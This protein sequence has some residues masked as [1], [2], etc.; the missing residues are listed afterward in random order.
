MKRKEEA[1]KAFTAAFPL[2][3]PVLTGFS[4]L[5]IAYGILMEKKGYGPLW[6]L[7]MSSIAFC[8]SMQYVAITLLTAVFDPIQAFLLSLMVN[9]RHLFYGICML[10]KYK[11]IG[12]V[13]NFL[14]Y[15]LCDETFSIVSSAKVPENVDRKWFYFWVS[16]L[17]YS[18]WVIASVIGGFLGSVIRMNTKSLDFVLTALFAVIFTEQLRGHGSRKSALIGAACTVLCLLVFGPQNFIIPSMILILSVLTFMKGRFEGLFHDGAANDTAI[19]SEVDTG[20]NEIAPALDSSGY[21]FDR[22][23]GHTDTKAVRESGIAEITASTAVRES[24]AV[25]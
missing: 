4:F 15:V 12:P 21:P 20:A 6:S 24:G 9:A 2:T 14:I 3:I 10:K 13:K 7:L 23:A 1:F 22:A 8:G 16:F 19:S 5:G 11:K 18:Y 17:D 25:K